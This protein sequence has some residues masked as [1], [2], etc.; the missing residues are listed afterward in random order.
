MNS[1]ENPHTTEPRVMCPIKPASR[2]VE[3]AFGIVGGDRH[4]IRPEKLELA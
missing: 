3:I 4:C 1:L 2:G